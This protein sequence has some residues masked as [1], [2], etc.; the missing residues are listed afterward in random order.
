M[1][2]KF[3]DEVTPTSGTVPFIDEFV[4][5]AKNL[6]QQ[7]Y[8]VNEIRRVRSDKG[9]LVITEKFSCF[10]W[11]NAKNTKQLIEALNFYIES[12]KGYEVVVFL[13]DTKKADFRMAVD[14]DVEVTWFTSKNGF[15]T[16]PVE[17]VSQ[18]INPDK[19]PFLPD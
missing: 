3:F 2:L 6:K 11:K 13:P 12:G 19:N 5:K 4:K 17:S 18:D 7:Q 8:P 10:L 14:F 16:T 1:A 9:Y 15:T